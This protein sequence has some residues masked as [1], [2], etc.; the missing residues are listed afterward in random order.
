MDSFTIQPIPSSQLKTRRMQQQT[1]A[2]EGLEKFRKATRRE[3]FC[4]MPVRC[5][6]VD[7]SLCGGPTIVASKAGSVRLNCAVGR[8]NG[9][10]RQ[11]SS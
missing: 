3:L 5:L 10:Q 4:D 6:R 1:L 11:K 2:D 8:A 9:E 7:Q